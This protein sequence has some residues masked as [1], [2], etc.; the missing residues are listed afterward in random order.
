MAEY[1][2]SLDVE[3]ADFIRHW[4]PRSQRYAGCDALMTFL[5]N[6]WQIEGDINFDEYWHGGARRVLI[7]SFNLLRDGELVVMRV[8]DNPALGRL[9]REM[10]LHHRLIPKR[11]STQEETPLKIK[12]AR[13]DAETY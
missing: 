1:T 5:D 11:A 7:Y 13:R 3:T 6:D 2:R 8:I 12:A 9:L 10:E 4:C